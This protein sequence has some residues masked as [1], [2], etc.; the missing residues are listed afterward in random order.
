MVRYLV[1]ERNLLWLKETR[2][3]FFFVQNYN[4]LLLS[5]V[6]DIRSV[7]VI[8]FLMRSDHVEMFTFSVHC[9]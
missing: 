1:V 3:T 6:V 4:L 9:V 5:L 7:A 8:L 2:S